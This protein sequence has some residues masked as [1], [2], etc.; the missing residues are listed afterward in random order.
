MPASSLLATVLPFRRI[1]ADQLPY[2]NHIPNALQKSNLFPPP[3]PPTHIHRS[4]TGQ[5]GEAQVRLDGAQV[6]EQ[7]GGL[8]ALDGGVDNDVVAG[9]PV[10]GGG[11]AVLVARLERVDDAQDLGAVAARRGRVREDGA[12]RLLG[13]DDED[14]ADGEGDA[15]GVDVGRVLEVEP[16]VCQS[17]PSSWSM[18]RREGLHVV[19]VGHLA[20]LVADDGE[21]D[22]RPRHLLDVLDPALVAADRVGRETE[23]LDAALGELGLEAGELAELGGADGRVVLGV[24][25]ED[26]P[27][28][29]NVLVEVNGALGGLGL[30]VGGRRAQTEAVGGGLA[31]RALLARTRQRYVRRGSLFLSHC[32]CGGVS[33]F[34]VMGGMWSTRRTGGRAG[35]R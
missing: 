33:V 30:E 31:T 12:D 35:Q 18:D 25:E 20:L 2:Q 28:V 26:E 24:G 32:M 15:L 8:L 10:D 27:V 23:E 19:E 21:V 1:P 11:D 17:L 13:V 6:G 29:A 5:R 22:L 9:D 34:W 7:L 3:S 14:G 16:G 4:S